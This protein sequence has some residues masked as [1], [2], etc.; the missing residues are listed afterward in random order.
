MDFNLTQ[1]EEKFTDSKEDLLKFLKI[2]GV[3]TRFISY[4]PLKIYINNL[5]FSKFSKTRE[6]TFKKQYPNISVLRSSLFQKICTRSS[7]VLSNK[8]NPRN[9][10][11]L[12]KKDN[13]INNLLAIVLEPYTRKY[14]IKLTYDIESDLIANPL[15]LDEKV[16][17]ILSGI[18]SG[19][20]IEFENETNI[21]YPFINIPKEWINSFLE[22]ENLNHIKEKNYSHDSQ[23]I[24]NS[25][26]SFLSEIL[27]PFRENVLVS[28]KYIKKH[29]K[30]K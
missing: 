21:I 16:N 11:L 22:L 2:I 9:S 17:H 4:T 29:L 14:G 15:I 7:R 1:K 5:R 12:P 3:D 30:I 6:K 28:E 20:G 23:I 24:A 13:S 27:P 10:I 26:M 8:L 18:F 25:F 19:D